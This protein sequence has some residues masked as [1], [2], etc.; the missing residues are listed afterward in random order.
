MRG[1]ALAI[2]VSKRENDKLMI[3]NDGDGDAHRCPLDDDKGGLLLPG[4]PHG[5]GERRLLLEA[6]QGLR[7]A[8]TCMQGVM[9]TARTTAWLDVAQ[10]TEQHD[11]M[12]CP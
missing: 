2:Q 9:A 12:S 7:P 4:A 5:P 11:P 6:R 1:L 10:W 3:D 8:F